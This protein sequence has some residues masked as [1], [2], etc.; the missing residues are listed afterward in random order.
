MTT[1]QTSTPPTR[2]PD[3]AALPAP[4]APDAP[5]AP[6]PPRLLPAAALGGL[7]CAVAIPVESAGVGWPIAGTV[8]AVA[9]AVVGRRT[10][11]GVRA[12]LPGPARSQTLVWAVAAV[13]LAAVACVRAAEWLVTLCLLTACV[14]GAL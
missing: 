3:A 13:A 8:L 12:L 10:V 5:D 11:G 14:A 2:W 6:L 7:G 4:A 9:V 1:G